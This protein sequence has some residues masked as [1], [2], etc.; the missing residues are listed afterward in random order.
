MDMLDIEA[1]DGDLEGL[2]D[3]VSS[4][5][6]RDVKD[7][8]MLLQI[9][10][11]L[12]VD[13]PEAVQQSPRGVKGRIIQ[14]LNSDDISDTPGIYDVL[15]K[16]QRD[17]NVFLFPTDHSEAGEAGDEAG[18]EDE[19]EEVASRSVG[20]GFG[21]LNPGVASGI[22]R[23]SDNFGGFPEMPKLDRRRST[24]F[25]VPP[26]SQGYGATSNAFGGL[27]YGA[28]SNALGGLGGVSGNTGGFGAPA[29][30]ADNFRSRLNSGISL[31]RGVGV[32]RGDG[33]VRSRKSL[34]GL[35]TRGRAVSMGPDSANKRRSSFSA[36]SNVPA[37]LHS[38][39]P[40]VPVAA[41]R[42]REFKIHGKIGEPPVDG[43]EPSGKD[44]D[45]LSYSNVMLQIEDGV[46]A[47][48]EGREIVSA[49][50]RA[51]TDPS[52]RDFLVEQVRGGLTVHGL[53]EVLGTHFSVQNATGL[54]KQMLRRSQREGESIQRFVQE[55]MK[56][57]DQ[58]L[59][60][61]AKEGGLYTANLMQD[62]FQKGVYNGLRSSEAR[63]ALRLTLKKEVLDDFD[64]RQE[65]SELMLDEADHETLVG[66]EKPLPKP[67]TKTVSVKQVTSKKPKADPVM[68]SVVQKLDEFKVDVTKDLADFKQDMLSKL[69]PT[70]SSSGT[71]QL[72]GNVGNFV[73]ATQ[74]PT[75]PQQLSDGN[76]GAIMGA[77]QLAPFPYPGA[78][79]PYGA[80]TGFAGSGRGVG[81]VD[82]GRGGR[83]GSKG[84]GRG[85]Q[86]G[87]RGGARHPL[88]RPVGICEIC[89]AANA[90]FCNH[91]LVC[92][93]V[94]HL[95]YYC[96]EKNNPAY[97]KPKNE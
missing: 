40:V 79:G 4:L 83:N 13:I 90:M 74:F 84:R 11:E 61:S 30:V 44:K 81:P 8:A 20:R 89:A 94:D 59:R 86:N 7:L 42:L 10:R 23:R 5:I 68:A 78:P 25:K 37:H 24:M 19:E 52:L 72:S 17:I 57:R 93:N 15:I 14:F 82:R 67:P 77:Y 64:L 54:Y 27:G 91:C 60:L 56:L 51:T 62:V 46:V 33:G 35:S 29:G 2:I 36:P 97:Q 66:E 75:G 38:S 21:I 28:G 96:P 45:N 73:A 34:S 18:D 71:H 76:A 31:G 26:N 69:A 47:G 80:N 49:V 1:D 39:V 95:S 43:V 41:H 22:T 9:A 87:N 48:Y 16:L 12:L 6:S 88:R 92:G 63:Q 55:M 32:G 53:K 85:N 70:V 50:V 58:V 65:I 3:A